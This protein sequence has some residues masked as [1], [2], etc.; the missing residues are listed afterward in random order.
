LSILNVL[1][2][3]TKSKLLSNE[4]EDFGD[5]TKGLI[6]DLDYN[7]QLYL[8]G[9]YISLVAKVVF[10]RIFSAEEKSKIRDKEFLKKRLS[11][12][13]ILNEKISIINLLNYLT[14]NVFLYDKI[15]EELFIH[16]FE[17]FLD[18]YMVLLKRYYNTQ[19]KHVLLAND[20][21]NLL[22]YCCFYH[23]SVRDI[24]LKLIKK[25]ANDFPFLLNEYK[26]FEY[27]VNILGILISNTL[28]PYDYF[29]KKI[30]LDQFNQ[31]ELPSEQVLYIN[32]IGRKGKNL[33]KTV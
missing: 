12:E 17:R 27:Y 21:R 20:L 7:S 19:F 3:K 11:Q 2:E 10:F 32:I 29:I 33:F 31:L 18:K 6:R 13:N 4:F 8:L 30:K 26:I 24:A 5:K 15:M 16:I 9:I 25:Y 22:N 14:D 1:S 23:D 28:Q